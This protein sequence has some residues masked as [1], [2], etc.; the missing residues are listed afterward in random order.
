MHAPCFFIQIR[1]FSRIFTK[2]IFRTLYGPSLTFSFLIR[3]IGN[4]NSRYM[5]ATYFFFFVFDA[6]YWKFNKYICTPGFLYPNSLF[7]SNFYKVNFPNTIWTL[8]NTLIFK[9]KYSEIQQQIYARHIFSHPNSLFF[10]N[11]YKVNFTVPTY[12]PSLT[13]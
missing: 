3:N 6:K 4:L 12:G 1:S 11:F 7:F 2:S 8:A 13:L 5:H 9:N 10:S